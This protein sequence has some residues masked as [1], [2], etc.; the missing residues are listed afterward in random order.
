MATAPTNYDKIIFRFF[1]LAIFV[2]QSITSHLFPYFHNRISKLYIKSALN[3]EA[4]NVKFI[5]K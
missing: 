1:V 5:A 2:Y 4:V 3:D